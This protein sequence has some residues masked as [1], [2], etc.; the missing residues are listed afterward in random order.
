MKKKNANLLSNNCF[1][2]Q[3]NIA[4]FSNKKAKTNMK[5]HTQKN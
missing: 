2:N 1:W 4:D 3:M 5:I